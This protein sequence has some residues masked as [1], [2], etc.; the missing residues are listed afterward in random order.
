MEGERSAF[1]DRA[2]GQSWPRVEML[3]A[4]SGWL[5][6]RSGRVFA[7]VALPLQGVVADKEVADKEKGEE[8]VSGPALPPGLRL[9]DGHRCPCYLHQKCP[10]S[11]A[12]KFTQ[13]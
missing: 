5:F 1:S 6:D 8:E 11:S 2:A 12:A 7:D 9:S 4:R 10:M 13:L 3:H